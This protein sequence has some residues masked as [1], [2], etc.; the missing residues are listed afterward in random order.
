MS[1]ALDLSINSVPVIT[2]SVP[3]GH[4]TQL[5]RSSEVK[6]MDSSPSVNKLTFFPFESDFLRGFPQTFSSFPPVYPPINI[7]SQNSQ[8]LQTPTTSK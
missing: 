2:A 8:L 4:V 5:P 3:S 6:S 7:P 1:E